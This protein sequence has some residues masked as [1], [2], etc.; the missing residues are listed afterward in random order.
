M[1]QVPSLLWKPCDKS[2]R[3]A[4][5]KTIHVHIVCGQLGTNTKSWSKN[6]L[7]FK[8]PVCLIIQTNLQSQSC[9]MLTGWASERDSSLA[10]RGLACWPQQ[11][12]LSLFPRVFFRYCHFIGSSTG[13]YIG[14]DCQQSPEQPWF[15]PSAS[16][17]NL[18]LCKYSHILDKMH[19]EC[20]KLSSEFF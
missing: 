18:D 7:A 19:L 9:H 8:W 17:N 20:L 11:A 5:S 10:V 4:A 15:L 2:G 12:Q 16:V 6:L 1:I 13:N 14:S 3:C